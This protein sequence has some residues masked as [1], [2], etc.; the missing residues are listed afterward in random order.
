MICTKAL[1]VGL[2]KWFLVL[3]G[4][5]DFENACK[6]QDEER[7]KEDFAASHYSEGRNATD[8]WYKWPSS[9]LKIR[10]AHL[11]GT[12]PLNWKQN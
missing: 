9:F 10:F 11:G 1:A 3:T 4:Q 12:H 5:T 6:T 7:E 8:P 2:E